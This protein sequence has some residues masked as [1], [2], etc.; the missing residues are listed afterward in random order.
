MSDASCVRF[1]TNLVR[2]SRLCFCLYLEVG[3]VTIYI[4]SC[5]FIVR[6]GLW[7]HVNVVLSTVLFTAQPTHSSAANDA[8]NPRAQ[9]PFIIKSVK[10]KYEDLF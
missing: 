10:T 9:E 3:S 5:L 8:I 2:N 7:G 4:L 6:V 1:I